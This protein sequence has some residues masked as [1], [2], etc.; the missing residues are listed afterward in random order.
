MF[1]DNFFLVSAVECFSQT[2]KNALKVKAG[3]FVLSL[4]AS[5]KHTELG[6]TSLLPLVQQLIDQ[7]LKSYR[8]QLILLM[9]PNKDI[10]EAISSIRTPDIFQGM[11]TATGQTP[12]IIKHFGL[13]PPKVVSLPTNFSREFGRHTTRKDQYL[14]RENYAYVPFIEQ[15]GQILNV[16]C[17]YDEIFSRNLPHPKEGVY[18][19]F[20]DGM[21]F[22]DS[23]FFKE[24][25]RA[26]R[27]LLYLDEV[28]VCN[29][30]G[31]KTHKL[32]FVYFTLLNLPTNF[33]SS[34][35]SIFLV[36]I[37]YANQVPDYDINVILRPI[38]EEI[39][40]LENGIDI[41][42]DGKKE[43]IFGTLV[44]VVADNLAS[45]QYGGFKA[46]FSRVFRK[47]RTCIAV[48]ADM[49]TFFCDTQFEH[50]SVEEHTQ[51]C[52]EL[53]SSGIIDP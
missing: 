39:S 1:N 17:I 41:E 35:T 19:S 18:A 11:T 8:E 16:K 15:L 43:N 23:E 24:H 12:F 28:Q 47:C 48:D 33:R 52:K 46:S 38:C 9:G 10:C 49:Q 25:P 3:E 7:V 30:L 36:A 20:E 40:Q 13:V 53:S 21:K 14:K 22:K 29:P 31:S 50:R 42:V 32:V 37:F 34:L 45:H 27:I 51:Q 6:I 26:L 4:L 2:S 44:A 5:N